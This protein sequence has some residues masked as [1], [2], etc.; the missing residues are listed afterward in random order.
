[1]LISFGRLLYNF[2]P[3]K[4]N[5][6]CPGFNLQIGRSNSPLNHKLL[7]TRVPG[8]IWVRIMGK[9][10][11]LFIPA[12]YQDKEAGL[13][14]AAKA[15]KNPLPFDFRPR[16]YFIFSNLD[17][18]SSTVFPG[19][20]IGPALWFMMIHGNSYTNLSPFLLTLFRR[21]ERFHALLE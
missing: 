3:R 16:W 19:L 17:S 8:N 9:K 10:V 14:F 4:A 2:A 20:P 21:P 18:S 7:I 15:I 11:S 13:G 5:D 12:L 6:R 1:M